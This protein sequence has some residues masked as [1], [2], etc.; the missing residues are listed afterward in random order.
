MTSRDSRFNEYISNNCGP[1][2]EVLVVGKV[3]FRKT[4]KKV[5]GIWWLFL[6][7]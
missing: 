3:T 6:N 4:F 2:D 1:E 5:F 7:L